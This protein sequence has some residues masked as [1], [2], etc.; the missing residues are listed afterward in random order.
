MLTVGIMAI[1]GVIGAAVSAVTSIV[2]QQI[3]TGYVSWQ[4]VGIAAISG[5]VSG[6]IA[7]S[8]LGLL[9]Q[10]A[11]GG[12]IGATSY[13]A[14][15]YVNDNEVQVSGVLWSFVG[16]TISGVI[17]GPGANEGYVLNDLFEQ[18][19]NI[20]AREMRRTNQAYAQK[21]I[22]RAIS[23][24]NNLVSY[25]IWSSSFRFTLG[26]ELSAKINTIYS[27]M[28]RTLYDSVGY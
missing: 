9:W 14:D 8:P 12:T 10:M 1:G 11:L 7:A 27:K 3:S 23:Y 21:A 6:A 20:I 26:V 15:C 19:S 25:K 18:T 22:A 5:F 13:I 4:S 17:S 28:A 2:T 16:G 24:R